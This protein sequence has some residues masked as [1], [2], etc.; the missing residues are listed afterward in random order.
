MKRVLGGILGLSCL[1][2][3][4]AQEGGNPVVINKV[5]AVVGHHHVITLQQ[6]KERGRRPGMSAEEIAREDPNDFKASVLDQMIREAMIVAEVRNR[7]GFVEPAGI[8]EELLK[9]HL[10]QG[11]ATKDL[12]FDTLRKNLIR[13]L[14]SEGRTLEEFTRELVDKAF[15]RYALE[16]IRESIQVSPKDVANEFKRQQSLV[17]EKG[18]YVSLAVVRIPENAAQEATQQ[19]LS[20]A[21]AK[22]QSED[23][24]KTLVEKHTQP[25][26]VLGL[27]MFFNDKLTWYAP[28]ND[29]SEAAILAGQLF[30]EEAKP[31]TALVEKFGNTFHLI[32]ITD[33]GEKLER[34]LDDPREQERIRLN[35]ARQKQDELIEHKIAL[36]KREIHVYRVNDGP[37]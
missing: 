5:L 34:K 35:L 19:A 4:K 21:A 16:P 30:G 13:E 1:G 31:N 20:A 18:Q 26:N 12:D 28:T 22:I 10:T 25:E 17:S 29:E 14:H 3:L 2:L 6:V 24:F 8:G 33:R 9:N 23:A 11:D 32:F 7:P 37:R 27:T 36:L 15:Y